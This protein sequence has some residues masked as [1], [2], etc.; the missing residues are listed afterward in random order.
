MILLHSSYGPG[1][2]AVFET[3]GVPQYKIGDTLTN[4]SDTGVDLLKAQS[5][6]DKKKVVV[7]MSPILSKIVSG[8]PILLRHI[9][10]IL[11]LLY[12]TPEGS[13]DVEFEQSKLETMVKIIKTP[14]THSM[15]LGYATLRM[16]EASRAS[17]GRINDG[18]LSAI[19]GMENGY[20][21]SKKESVLIPSGLHLDRDLDT[22]NRQDVACGLF[23]KHTKMII[24][25]ADML[26]LTG[27]EIQA[28]H[29]GLG[30]LPWWAQTL[31]HQFY[32]TR[33]FLRYSIGIEGEHRISQYDQVVHSMYPY[34][35]YGQP[36]LRKRPI[37]SMI[38]GHYF[39]VAMEAM[40][41]ALPSDE[42]AKFSKGSMQHILMHGLPNTEDLPGFLF[43]SRTPIQR[44]NLIGGV[45]DAAE[46]ATGDRMVKDNILLTE[47]GSGVT[48]LDV[49]TLDSWHI[50]TRSISDVSIFTSSRSKSESTYLRPLSYNFKIEL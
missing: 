22:A 46:Y 23:Q 40:T 49:E 10:E 25:I 4:R 12:P 8:S 2:R 9:R 50:G 48:A 1:S 33:S 15:I 35:L 45:S 43:Y 32:I 17:R 34:F 3:F 24:A 6:I 44:A 47:Y 42:R 39:E 16:L 14:L 21:K 41:N 5:Y 7:M 18:I 26:K 28:F 13:R 36:D 20:V 19:L 38:G 11:D 29:L 31:V 30:R 37:S 27:S